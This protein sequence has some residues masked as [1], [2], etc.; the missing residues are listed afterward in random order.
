MV[1][2]IAVTLDH[3][4]VTDLDRWVREGRNPIAAAFCAIG[5]RLALIL[6]LNVGG[7]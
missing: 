4:A 2:R 7:G 1:R 5:G 3:K 6:H